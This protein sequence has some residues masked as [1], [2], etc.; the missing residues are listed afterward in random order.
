MILQHIWRAI[1]EPSREAR[2]YVE[3]I[4]FV[5]AGTYNAAAD[6]IRRII[7]TIDGVADEVVS[8]YNLDSYAELVAAGVSVDERQRIFET[9]WRGQRV[10]DWARAPL[11]FVDNPAEL[12]GLW[13]AATRP[14]EDETCA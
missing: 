4:V 12:Y 1:V 9:G 3:R 7:A 14:V 6:K 5:Q 13:L 10:C 2:P 11:F 8:F